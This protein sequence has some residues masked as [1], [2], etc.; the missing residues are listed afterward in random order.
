MVKND[1]LA[2]RKPCIGCK[3]VLPLTNYYRAKESRDGHGGR[4]RVCTAD[5]YNRRHRARRG[6]AGNVGDKERRILKHSHAASL[7]PGRMEAYAAVQDAVR[8][9]TLV[10]QPCSS[11][12]VEPAQAHHESYERPLD[13]TWL[14]ARCHNRLHRHQ[15]KRNPVTNKFMPALEGVD[16]LTVNRRG[17]YVMAGPVDFG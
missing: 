2:T 4:C 15:F 16:R 14:C 6:V 11:C 3:K 10:R 8:R 17:R 9:G 12:G 1:P 5:D 7:R 13:V